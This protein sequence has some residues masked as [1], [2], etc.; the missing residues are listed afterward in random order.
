M[1]KIILTLSMVLSLGFT[2]NAATILMC[3]SN[4]Q[5]YLNVNGQWT[6]A[7][8]CAFGP[9]AEQLDFVVPTGNPKFP[10]ASEELYLVLNRLTLTIYEPTNQQKVELAQ[11]RNNNTLRNVFVNPLK[12]NASAYAILYGNSTNLPLFYVNVSKN[13]STGN[14]LLNLYSDEQRSITV[15]CKSPNGLVEFTQNI[16]VTRGFNSNSLNTNSLANGA[17]FLTISTSSGY[18]VNVKLIVNN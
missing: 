1:K 4:G 6:T 13:S 9:W 17:H 11:M 8:G 3:L 16:D 14:D 7:G 15:T 2:I 12:L 10:E 5:A 18:Q